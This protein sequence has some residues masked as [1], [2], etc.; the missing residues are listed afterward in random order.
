M[1]G[2]DAVIPAVVRLTSLRVDHYN[3]ESNNKELCINLDLLDEVR[4]VAEQRL[5]WY[6]N[7]MTMHYNKRVKPRHFNRGELV[8]RRVTLATRDLSQ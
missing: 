3:K 4:T 1:F 7:L 5:A 2:T 8:L 6:Q